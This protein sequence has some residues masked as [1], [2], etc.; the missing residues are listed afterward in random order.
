MLSVLAVRVTDSGGRVHIDSP[1]VMS[2]NIFGGGIG[3]DQVNL[4]SQ[5][6]ACSMGQLEIIP[7]NPNSPLP[8]YIE[9]ADGVIEVHIAVRTISHARR[10]L[11]EPIV[12]ASGISIVFSNHSFFRFLLLG[13]TDTPSEMLLLLQLKTNLVLNC[14]VHTNKLCSQRRSATKLQA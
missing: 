4:R 3:C 9:V 13:M 5:M 6:Y 11:F 12:L 7:G 14:L 8:K 1:T 10:Q 2:D